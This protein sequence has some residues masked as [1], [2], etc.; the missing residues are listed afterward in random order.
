[1]LIFVV[2]LCL[3]ASPIMVKKKFVVLCHCAPS[4]KSNWKVLGI[5][6]PPWSLGNNECRLRLVKT[7]MSSVKL[8][9]SPYSHGFFP[10]C[11]V[12]VCLDF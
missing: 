4:W 1:M 8:D 9:Y 11:F 10:V 2:N 6:C 3:K 7:W 12:G 5:C